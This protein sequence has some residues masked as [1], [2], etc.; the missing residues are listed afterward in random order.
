MVL[1]PTTPLLS[2]PH[3]TDMPGMSLTE[4][5]LIAAAQARREPGPYAA[6]VTSVGRIGTKKRRI[7]NKKLDF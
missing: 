5:P 4:P 2:L 6:F 7:L 3:S 1:S